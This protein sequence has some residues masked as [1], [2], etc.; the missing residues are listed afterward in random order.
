MVEN[1]AVFQSFITGLPTRFGLPLGGTE[2][3]EMGRQLTDQYICLI[4]NQKLKQAQAEC[5]IYLIF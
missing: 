3:T 5:N 1:A 4:V 2:T